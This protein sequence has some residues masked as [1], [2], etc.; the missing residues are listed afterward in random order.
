MDNRLGE[1]DEI[2]LYNPGNEAIRG[3]DQGNNKNRPKYSKP[4]GI[5]RPDSMKLTAAGTSIFTL[6]VVAA[7]LL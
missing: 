2:L 7:K 5:K 1:L 6:L 4:Y 3:V